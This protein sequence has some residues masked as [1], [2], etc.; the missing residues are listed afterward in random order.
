MNTITKQRVQFFH[1]T[2]Q[3]KNNGETIGYTKYMYLQY[4]LWL[5][6]YTYKCRLSNGTL[7]PEEAVCKDHLQSQPQT[8][9]TC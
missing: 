1:S 5:L 2:M 4:H 3:P 8:Q 9:A 7:T 6:L